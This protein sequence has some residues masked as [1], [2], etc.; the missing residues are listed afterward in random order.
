MVQRI[1]G[2][3]SLGANADFLKLGDLLLATGYSAKKA[4]QGQS[5]L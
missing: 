4:D 2:Y 3:F 1:S 5:S